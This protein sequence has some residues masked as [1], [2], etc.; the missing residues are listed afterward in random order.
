MNWGTPNGARA[1]SEAL[2]DTDSDP[3]SIRWIEIGGMEPITDS[4][5]TKR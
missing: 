1:D 2:D 3:L 5:G 4:N